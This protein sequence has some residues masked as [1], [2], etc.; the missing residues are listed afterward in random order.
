MEIS[1]KK[2][3]NSLKTEK[4]KGIAKNIEEPDIKEAIPT[5]QKKIGACK[6]LSA[7]TACL[8]PTLKKFNL[9]YYKELVKSTYS[10]SANSCKS[11]KDFEE[12]FK[13]IDY[14]FTKDKNPMYYPKINKPLWDLKEN[15]GYG[16][17]YGVYDNS[18]YFCYNI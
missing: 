8:E 7:I 4:P 3:R 9:K 12:S 13:Y 2:L 1:I 18:K 10:I 15:I 6:N 17:E 5:M 11:K 14:R 16:N